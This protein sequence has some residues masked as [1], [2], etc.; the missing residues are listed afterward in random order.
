VAEEE[1]FWSRRYAIDGPE[2]SRVVDLLGLG[3]ATTIVVD[4]LLP[5]AAALAQLS[6]E[7]I[8]L[9]AVRALYL[10]HPRLP[11]NEITR[12]MT[13]QFFGADHARAAIVNS[14]CRQQG[15]MQLYRDFCLNEQETC[16]ECAFP[17]LV[18]RLERLQRDTFPAGP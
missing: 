12:E 2:L 14:A 9:E 5:A 10:C 17:R 6:C 18:A 8:S 7:P 13:Q 16:Q 15:L 11:A 1:D 4:V 3:R